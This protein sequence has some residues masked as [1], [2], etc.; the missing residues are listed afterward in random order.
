MKIKIFQKGFNYSQDGHGNRLVLHLQG[1]NMKCPWCSNPEGM[2]LEGVPVTGKEHPYPKRRRQNGTPLS[3][4]EYT[5][6]ELVEECIQ[7][8]PMF[9][10]GGGVTLTG[11]EVTMQFDAVKEVLYRLQSEGIHTAIESN[12]SH[13]RMEELVPFVNQWIMDVKHYDDKKHREWLGVSNGNTTKTLRNVSKIHP[14][15]LIRVP[16]IPGFNDSEKDAECFAAYF[17]ENMDIENVKVEF[18]AYHEFGKGKWEQ[19][20]MEYK[21]PDV[22]LA[23]GTVKFFEAVMNANG[24]TCV[25]T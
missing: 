11:G 7:A 21:M 24:I 12:G 4:E 8:K 15:M 3:Y 25:R 13:P 20:G 22:R 18:L 5:I 16:L 2:P 17:R 1:C 19:C 9:F 23:P 6:D 14:D 10:E